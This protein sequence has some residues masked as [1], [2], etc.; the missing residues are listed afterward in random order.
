MKGKQ[1]AYGE[2]RVLGFDRVA[3]FSWSFP[4]CVFL[5]FLSACSSGTDSSEN[6]GPGGPGGARGALPVIE[7]FESSVPI[8]FEQG[9]VVLNW[10]V[11]TRNL[12]EVQLVLTSTEAG[13]EQKIDAVGEMTVRVTRSST[14]VLKV[15]LEQTE[16]TKRLRVPVGHFSVRPTSI[17]SGQ[18]ARLIWNVP[19][20]RTVIVSSGQGELP[21][22]GTRLVSPA[23]PT[24]YILRVPA[25][26]PGV[27]ASVFLDVLPVVS[28]AL[29]AHP[30]VGVAP[31]V[32]RFSPEVINNNTVITTYEWDFDG[33]GDIDT[34]DT[35]GAPQTYTYTGDP[36]DTFTAVLKVVPAQG[37]PVMTTKTIR[38]ENAPPSV[39]VVPSITNGHIPLEVTFSVVARDPEGIDA[40]EVDYE[41]DGTVDETQS[42][43]SA[44]SGTWRFLRIYDSE[45]R[46]EAKVR[47]TDAFGEETLVRHNF[48]TVDANHPKDPV[49][50][51][52]AAT[53][54]KGRAP[55]PT[56]LTATAAFFDNDV[57]ARWQW[58]LDG[59]GVFE[60]DLDADS[61]GQ[62][63]IVYSRVGYFYPS[64]KAVSTSG[65]SAIASVRVEAKL[66]S[67]P[68]LSIPDESDSI[69]AEAAET[70]SFEVSLAFETELEVWMED[71]S[72]A[73]VRTLRPKSFAPIDVYPFEWD[74]HDEA[75]QRVS[76]GDYYVVM[77]YTTYGA[78]SLLDLRQTTGGK[79][80]YYARKETNPRTFDR[81]ESPLVIHYEV[82]DPAE[83]SFFWQVSFG[84]RLMTL[85]EH[86]RLGRGRYSLY[87]NG[88]YPSGLKVPK[89]IVSLPG[90]VR[91]A[92]PDNVIF[93]KET[94]RIEDYQL[95]S[96]I[97]A[98]PRREPIEFYVVLSKPSTLEL[99]VADMDKGV[100]V[101]TRVYATLPAGEQTLIW[102]AKN[103]VGQYLAP[104]DYR[105][106]IRSVDERGSRS[107]FWFRTQRIQY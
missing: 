86:E 27:E 4:G 66:P 38:L 103:D 97:I 7:S 63:S 48:I 43:Q 88:D 9:E 41:N 33:D 92:L 36:G 99:V 47:V 85:M 105:M 65:R 78:R 55:M 53:E 77:A 59:D 28:T 80:S 69:D 37:E 30:V 14:F 84:D 49:V 81:L 40:I 61:Q 16:I 57:L 71:A 34:M 1:S 73:P 23:D 60:M 45:G 22:S 90:I 15:R 79:L 75:G 24:E 87:W 58:D 13:V 6:D 68:Q 83:V 10:S 3:A 91:Y 42:G 74:G 94:P 107:M 31:L 32:V 46:Y 67:P 51:L 89:E 17:L 35:F 95:R 62:A 52:L 102:D 2:S 12:N 26:G 72:R 93:V 54:N 29:V 20:V 21:F 50:G 39:E 70:A 104:G 11:D 8:V 44:T 101:A 96:T 5:S 98:D 25:L 19:G 100:D 76:E 82:D 64:V 56:T 18:S 106:G